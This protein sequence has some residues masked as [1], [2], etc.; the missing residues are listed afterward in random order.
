MPATISS[1]LPIPLPPIKEA[2]RREFLDN[3]AKLGLAE[4][5]QGVNG[6][7][8]SAGPVEALVELETLQFRFR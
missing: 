7:H 4:V 5:S 2:L 6:V 8:L 1:E 3:Q